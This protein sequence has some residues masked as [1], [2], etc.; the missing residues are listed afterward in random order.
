MYHEHF[1]IIAM[2]IMHSLYSY[3]YFF[4]VV[5]KFE[6]PVLRACTFGL[7]ERERHEGRHCPS[8]TPTVHSL[9]TNPKA[10]T[11]PNSATSPAF[12]LCTSP[13]SERCHVRTYKHISVA[14]VTVVFEPS[15][16]CRPA[17]VLPSPKHLCKHLQLL[18]KQGY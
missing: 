1:Y 14:H 7:E 2:L 18:A 11:N 8:F 6:F 10:I 3:T 12:L 13:T 17:V 9:L 4:L 16:K 5:S 15:Q